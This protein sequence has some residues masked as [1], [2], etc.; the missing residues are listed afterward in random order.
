MN[1]NNN[2]LIW[3]GNQTNNIY[4]NENNITNIILQYFNN[5]NFQNITNETKL[6]EDNYENYI[7]IFNEY[8]LIITDNLYIM[9]LS[10]IYSTSCILFKNNYAE[11]DSEILKNLDYIKYIHDI[12]DLEKNIFELLNASS[13]NYNYTK[14]Y[15]HYYEEV[16]REF[17]EIQ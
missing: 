2:I 16:L 3:F 8:K 11:E 4:F 13:M 17:N 9:K 12:K 15:N 7:P 14:L 5:I 6:L 10:A 1:K